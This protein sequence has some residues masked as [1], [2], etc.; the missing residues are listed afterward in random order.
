MEPPSPLLPGYDSTSAPAQDRAGGRLPVCSCSQLLGKERTGSWRPPPGP[1]AAGPPLRPQSGAPPAGPTRLR[2]ARTPATSPALTLS[3]QERRSG[4]SGDRR[5]RAR[6]LQPGA[7]DYIS[8]KAAGLQRD[9]AVGVRRHGG[10]EGKAVPVASSG[11]PLCG[12]CRS[13]VCP[14]GT[15]GSQAA[16]YPA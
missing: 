16:P 4:S 12:R 11:G 2:L 1:S 13:S 3:Q 14:G 7:P 6:R 10:P 8:H 5:S 15:R 9:Q